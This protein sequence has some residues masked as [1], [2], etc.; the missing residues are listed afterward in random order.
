MGKIPSFVIR[1]VL[2]TAVL[3][4]AGYIVS[5]QVLGDSRFL[6]FVL[7]VLGAIPIVLFSPGLFS[8]FKSGALHTPKVIFR[9]VETKSEPQKQQAE[10][11]LP[12]ISY[13][14]AGFLTWLIGW[15]LQ[16]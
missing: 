15:L 11:I 12:S 5:Y 9:K 16:L 7:F 14:S 1:T 10:T 13:I 2:A 8:R 6:D 4:A 3:V